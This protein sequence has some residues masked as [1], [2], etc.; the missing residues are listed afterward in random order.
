VGFPHGSRG[1]KAVW[2]KMA[3]QSQVRRIVAGSKKRG[4]DA[5][6]ESCQEKQGTVDQ[7]SGI[8]C[9][10]TCQHSWFSCRNRTTQSIFVSRK[11]C[12]GTFKDGCRRPID[13]TVAIGIPD[14]GRAVGECST[15]H[16]HRGSRRNGFFGGSSRLAVRIV[17]LVHQGNSK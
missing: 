15:L 12:Q 17:L 4:R 1:T 6:S 5:C 2:K 8:P 13:G 7:H 10:A 3:F 9:V 14:A 11:S 16:Q